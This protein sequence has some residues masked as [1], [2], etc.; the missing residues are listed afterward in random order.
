MD[1]INAPLCH[2]LTTGGESGFL[3]R[4]DSSVSMGTGGGQTGGLIQFCP[5]HIGTGDVEVLLA[6]SVA[7]VAGVVASSTTIPGKVFLGANASACRPV[8]MAVQ[9]LYLG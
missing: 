5:G 3:L 1:P 7:G 2:P 9:A 6:A 4:A 8:A